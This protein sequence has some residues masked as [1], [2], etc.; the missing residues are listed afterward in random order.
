MRDCLERLKTLLVRADEDYLASVVANA[1]D[2]SDEEFEDFLLSN[3]LWGGAGSVAD[4]AGVSR[5]GDV[6]VLKKDIERTLMELGRMQIEAGRTNART[7]MWV[8]AF[9]H[10][11]STGVR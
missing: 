1:L 7:N 5:D 8:D 2:G 6:H 3:A 11:H 4:Q 10:W 9:E